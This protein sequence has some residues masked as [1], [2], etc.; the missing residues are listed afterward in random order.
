[1]QVLIILLQCV[2][3]RHNQVLGHEQQGGILRAAH[4]V[5]FDQFADRSLQR[6]WK[7]I[8]HKYIQNDVE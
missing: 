6:Q 1:M 4:P 5:W 3:Q 7:D 8:K 2:R